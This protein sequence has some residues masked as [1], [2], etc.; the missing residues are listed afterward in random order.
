MMRRSYTVFRGAVV[1]LWLGSGTP[2]LAQDACELTSWMSQMQ[3]NSSR[4]LELPPTDLVDTLF[5]TRKISIHPGFT[6][7]MFGR[8][9]GARGIT[10]APDGVIYVAARTEGGSVLA[11][12]DHDRDGEAD[13]VVKV[14]T[15]AGGTIHGIE[16]INGILHYSTDS[17]LVRGLDIDGDRTIDEESVIATFPPGGNHVTRTF[18][19]DEA[20]NKIYLQIGST[21]NVCEEDNELRA[22]VVE[23]NPDGSE[24]R[25]FARG[26]RNAV[27][28]DID[29]RTG[30]L[31]VNSNDADNI[32]PD[33]AGTNDSPKEGIFIV[34]DGA[35]YGWPYAHG[36]QMRIPIGPQIDTQTIRS[37]KGP[38]AMVLAHSAPLGLHF[39]RGTT[40]PAKYHG[41]IFQAYHGSWNRTPPA[42]PRI[43]VMWADPD[44]QNAVVQDFVNGFQPDSNSNRWGRPVDLTEGADGALYVTNDYSGMV[45][46]IAYTDGPAQVHEE[47][48]NTA[49]TLTPNPA[50]DKITIS[51]ASA[52]QSSLVEI[53]DLLGNV[54]KS[55]STQGAQ[56]EVSTA[57]LADGRY[58]VRLTQGTSVFT[59]SLIVH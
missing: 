12:P 45:H 28:M 41:A 14:K 32:G 40:W 49:F 25:I 17:K 51:F 22:T 8:A 53:I 29:P 10:L 11:M 50:S 27:G 15:G 35:H 39:L 30:A 9:Q 2:T 59:R 21:C 43:T 4:T 19:Y 52:T 54:Q 6:M 7:T 31:W 3:P 38:V 58:L 5:G 1:A 44:G 42:P 56:I 48:A 33:D 18:V 57:S 26:L 46:R 16:F 34:C 13:S 37:F 55:V 36:Y 20:R 47:N 23:L 24:M